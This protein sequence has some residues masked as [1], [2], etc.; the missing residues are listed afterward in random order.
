MPTQHVVINGDSRSMQDVGSESVQLIIT[1]PPYWQ[2]KDY[3]N[4]SQIGYHD[5]Y[6]DYIDDLN[7][8]W[9][10]CERVLSPGCRL[11]I[12][13]GDQFA[14]AAYYG[15]YKVI[16]IREQIV[17]FCETIGLDYMGAIIWQK[18][19]NTK[20]SGGGLQMGSF[21][22][23]RNG[24]VKIDY[25][26]ILIFKKLGDA[27]RPTETEREESRLSTEEWN[28]YFAGHWNFSG[29]RQKE[30]L[31]MF[32]EELPRR[33]IKMFS[34]VGETVLDPF[35]G[36]GTTASVAR[37]LG[38][39]SVSIEINPDF[40]PLIQRRLCADTLN[41]GGDQFRFVVQDKNADFQKLKG[42]LP[43]RCEAIQSLQRIVDPKKM[44][45]GSKIDSKPVAQVELDSVERV[46][47]S[48]KVLLKDGRI[49]TLIGIVPVA[50]T[51]ELAIDYLKKKI[52]K[53]RIYLKSDRAIPPNGSKELYAY[54]YLEN[55]TFVN[56]HLIRSGFVSVDN[57]FEYAA[58]SKFMELWTAV[59]EHSTR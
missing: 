16:P 54:M 23:P 49:V 7:V 35:A 37:Q 47:S 44:S 39:N 14:R 29:A 6:E 52:G 51:E 45:F 13:I 8:V 32:P 2:L 4:D 48:N 46:V 57:S 27:P 59:L 17:R 56:A 15:R 26:F 41:I 25:E 1:S 21:P 55:K 30:H 36:S 20:T 11:C 5:S 9:K 24:I 58:R 40:I 10:E 50:E 12:N 42:S 38:R 31:A 33:L 18:V 53:N 34:F 28:T 43:Y 19:T 22:F 3:G